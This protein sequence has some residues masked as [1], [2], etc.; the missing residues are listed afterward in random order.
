MYSVIGKD[1]IICSNTWLPLVMSIL[2]VF[3]RLQVHI[4]EAGA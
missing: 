2:T 4:L 1:G 3:F